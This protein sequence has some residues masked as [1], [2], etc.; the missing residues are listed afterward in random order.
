[1]IL[2]DTSVWIEHFRRGEP[3]L[4]SA[5]MDGE[6][7]MHPFIIGELACG[8]FG[9]RETALALLAKLPLTRV[10]THQEALALIDRR[11]LMGRGIG[12]VDAHLLAAAALTPHTRLWTVDR[13]LATVA[14][15]LGLG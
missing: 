13:R 11:K 2:A 15:S 5:L 14:D 8:N 12:Y 3:R 10:A 6:V 7:L 1:V 9:N 4:Q